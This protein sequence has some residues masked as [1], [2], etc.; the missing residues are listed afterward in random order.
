M[1]SRFAPVSLHKR[2]LNA[3]PSR[4]DPSQAGWRR[5]AC[6]TNRSGGSDEPGRCR[7]D[8]SNRSAWM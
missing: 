7:H 6:R 3:K 2:E 5:T 8:G 1:Q 4:D